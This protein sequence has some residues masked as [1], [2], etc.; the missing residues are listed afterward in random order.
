MQEDYHTVY[1]C[2]VDS[3]CTC[4]CRV[5][6]LHSFIACLDSPLFQ[7]HPYLKWSLQKHFLPKLFFFWGGFLN[8]LPNRR[9]TLLLCSRWRL[10]ALE[11]NSFDAGSN[12]LVLETVTLKTRIRTSATHA[13]LHTCSYMYQRLPN[14]PY[15][16][17][18]ATHTC[19]YSPLKMS[20]ITLL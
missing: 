7:V 9:P 17:M 4:T 12:T 18:I 5:V 19:K 1:I 15:V 11:T 14:R 20:G 16:E 2:K 8:L 6:F 3:R 10:L 13:Q